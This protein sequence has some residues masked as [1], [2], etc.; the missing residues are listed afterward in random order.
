MALDKLLEGDTEPA[1][2]YLMKVIGETVSRS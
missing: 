2:A 1:K